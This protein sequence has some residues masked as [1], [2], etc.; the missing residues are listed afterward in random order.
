MP[1]DYRANN[2]P[3]LENILTNATFYA[4]YENEV[5]SIVEEYFNEDYL[6]ARVDELKAL[7]ADYVYA[8]NNKMYSNA[9]FDT[10]LEQ[11]INLGGGGGGGGGGTSYGLKSFVSDRYEYLLNNLNCEISST[12]ELLTDQIQLFPNP[13]NQFINV[14]FE[15]ANSNEDRVLRLFSIAGVLLSEIDLPTTGQNELITLDLSQYSSGIYIVR[16]FDERGSFISKL[17]AKK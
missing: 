6:H 13:T 9:N 10:N 14:Q 7:I 16:V 5:C 8:D 12:G 17:I 15:G 11:N 4:R 3:L 1:L 2:R